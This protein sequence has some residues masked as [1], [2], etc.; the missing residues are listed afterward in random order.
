MEDANERRHIVGA[1]TQQ[2]GIA[3]RP[4]RLATPEL[5]Q[6]CALEQEVGRVFRDGQPVQQ[7]LQAVPGQGQVEVLLRRVGVLLEP[8]TDGGG[9]VGG[10]VVIASM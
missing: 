1:E 8:R 2:V 5:E 9:T 7:A 10:H 3:C 4:V 6:Q